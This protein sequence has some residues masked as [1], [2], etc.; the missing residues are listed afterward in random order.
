MNRIVVGS[1]I[2]AAAVA[3][4]VS[5]PAVAQTK[6]PAVTDSNLEA[7]AKQMPDCKEFRNAC[8][9]C[10]RLAD[11]KLGC[12]NIGVACNPSGSW[13]CSIPTKSGEPTK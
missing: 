10:V 5:A 12:S 3:V 9:V 13:Q 6:E 1:A 11:G 4:A 2:A 7:L 8:Q